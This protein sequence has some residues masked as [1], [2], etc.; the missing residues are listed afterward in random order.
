MIL[1]NILT[2]LISRTKFLGMLIH[3]LYLQTQEEWQYVFLITAGVYLVGGIMYGLLASGERQDWSRIPGEHDEFNFATV[4]S[5]NLTLFPYNG[6][7]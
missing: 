2:L 3:I 4:G 6:I 1:S 5:S 7:L